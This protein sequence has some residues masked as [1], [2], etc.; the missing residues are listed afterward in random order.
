M[1]NDSEI[2]TRLETID[3]T[4]NVGFAALIATLSKPQGEHDMITHAEFR[5][6]VGTLR[7]CAK[8]LG[9]TAH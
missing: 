4:L 6:A 8:A 7:E 1:N 9:Y 2:L 5:E 3:E